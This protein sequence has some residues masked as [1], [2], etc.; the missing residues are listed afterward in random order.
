MSR[1]HSDSWVRSPARYAVRFCRWVY[2]RWLAGAFTLAVRHLNLFSDRYVTRMGAEDPKL[3]RNV[4]YSGMLH[5][6][7]LIIWL[8][9]TMV[10]GLM[11]QFGCDEYN[12]PA[13][14]KPKK[15]Q[16][17][18]VRVK[19]R[20]KALVN[21]QAPV[22]YNPP[23]A[24]NIDLNLDKLTQNAQAEG[25]GGPVGLGGKGKGEIRFI[26]LQYSGG[27]W[28]QDLKLNSGT[29]LLAKMGEL[30]YPVATEAEVKTIRQLSAFKEG[31]APPFVYMTGGGGIRISGGEAAILRKYLLEEGGMIFADNGGGGFHHHFRRMMAQVLQGVSWR[32]IDL[33]NDHPIYH[34]QFHMDGAPPLWHHSGYR[35]LGAVVE[36]RLVCFYHQGDIGDAWKDG[37]SG[38][39]P[40]VVEWAFKCGINVIVFA[41]DQ[42][43]ERLAAQE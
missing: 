16:K 15:T 28:D 31:K 12:I 34:S 25:Q 10:P 43:R 9:F 32:E 40:D 20:R 35:A 36:G 29:N 23:K 7:F 39:G 3:A 6:L 42:Y 27:D 22:A 41:V 37:N 1:R 5:G 38:A 13:G 17:R 14:N 8:I 26:R 30:G 24:E 4:S 21:P 11:Q 18:Q 2:A 33:P 19:I